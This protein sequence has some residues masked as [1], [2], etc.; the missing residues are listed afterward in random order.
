MMRTV[1]CLAALAAL[2]G[3]PAAAGQG[4]IRETDAGVV[5]EYSGDESDVRAGQAQKA[6]EQQKEAEAEQLKDK[7]ASIAQMKAAQR[8][9]DHKNDE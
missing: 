2:A 5:V 6:E 4:T 3:R 9:L 1:V 7:K 8:A